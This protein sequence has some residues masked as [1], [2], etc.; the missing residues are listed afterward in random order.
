MPCTHF[1]I[2]ELALDH[3]FETA[4]WG[5]RQSLTLRL[6]T[7][8]GYSIQRE[9]SCNVLINGV[10]GQ[11]GDKLAS[12][13]GTRKIISLSNTMSGLRRAAT[14]SRTPM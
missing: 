14:A 7:L 3:S 2:E 10:I 4:A 8:P 1:L 9:H 13:Q 12:Y 6:V 11:S 5:K